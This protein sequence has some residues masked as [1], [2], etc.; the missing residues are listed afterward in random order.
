MQGL[1]GM[2]V[3]PVVI[4][5]RHS[6]KDGKPCKWA[7]DEFAKKCDCR[8]HLRWRQNGVQQ[9]MKANTR[10]WARAE[11]VKRELEDRLSGRSEDRAKRESV[12]AKADA[13]LKLLSDAID[14]FLVD[15]TTQGLSKGVI[16]GYRNMLNRLKAYCHER[17]IYIVRGIT[18]DVLT[19]FVAD[20]PTIYPSSITRQKRRE[21]L[22]SFLRYC[23]EA[24]WLERVPAVPSSRLKKSPPCP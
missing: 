12:K 6:T 5:V 19:M 1:S 22:R 4:F 21:R 17:G 23:F 20:W 10:S 8:K 18:A 11:E 24:Q 9:R 13:A 3:T 14:I 16:S 15:K 2:N 7:G